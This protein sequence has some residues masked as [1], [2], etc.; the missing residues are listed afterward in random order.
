MRECNCVSKLENKI[1]LTTARPN[2]NYRKNILILFYTVFFII[3]Y[4]NTV[5]SETYF[6]EDFESGN[7]NKWT[8][9]AHPEDI[10]IDNFAHSGSRSARIDYKIP[11]GLP[12]HRS[13]DVYLIKNF[14]GGNITA[15]SVRGY[16]YV[17]NLNTPHD[18]TSRTWRKL[19][20]IRGRN[21]PDS[22]SI[23]LSLN[24]L[25]DPPRFSMS[26][27]YLSDNSQFRTDR[28]GL[29]TFNYDTWNCV[30]LTVVLNTP[31]QPNGKVAAYLNGKKIY[32]NTS[33]C[34]RVTDNPLRQVTVGE[35]V[36]KNGDTLSRNVH[37][38]WDDI[39]I[40]SQYIGPIN[41]SLLYSTPGII[42]SSGTSS[43]S[44]TQ[45]PPPAPTSI[46]VI[47]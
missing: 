32:E 20:Y 16:V 25:W 28:Y 33:A 41:N 15:F 42:P 1:Y 26:C 18:G 6:Y 43:T 5:Y 44:S 29:S 2:N 11:S 4:I 27:T 8:L 14:E 7:F 37:R 35:Q 10:K 46:R 9:L 47:N 45:T 23:T 17:P 30:E 19:F 24:D 40:S 12:E 31:G 34:I 38:Y 3:F 22:W 36:D 39:V 13:R 21:H